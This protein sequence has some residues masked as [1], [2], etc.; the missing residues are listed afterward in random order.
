MNQETIEQLRRLKDAK[1]FFAIAEEMALGADPPT[2]PRKSCAVTGW[3]AVSPAGWNAAALCESTTS[4]VGLATK[5]E[6]RCS[7]APARQFRPVPPHSAP[8]DWMKQP[9]FRRNTAVARFAVHAA[10]EALGESKLAQVQSGE[11]RIGIIFCTMNGCVQFSRRFFTEVLDNP[12]LASPIFF[13][14]T[15]YNAPSSHIAAILGAHDIN[16]TLVGDSAQ[17]IAGLALAEQWLTDGVVEACLVVAAE[18]L[19]WL[20]DEAIMLFGKRRVAA[21]GAAAV[22][23]EPRTQ[24]NDTMPVLQHVT[25]TRT[26]GARLSRTQA[27][28]EV[29][30]E[31]ELLSEFKGAV[32]F[33]GLGVGKHVDEPEEEAW[34]TWNQERVSVRRVL[35][36]GLAAT[37]GWQVVAA[38][39]WLRTGLA[40]QSLVSA[41]GLSQQAAGAAFGVD[42]R[43][44]V[45]EKVLQTPRAL[46]EHA[47]T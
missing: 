7:G 26:F 32:L 21:E 2:N 6:S 37:S 9:R 23:L 22:L 10:V 16:Y 24:N 46:K 12:A 29:A 4:G 36:E 13:P 8:P 27:A 5:S 3:G 39:E 15:V 42:P 1:Q 17:F 28:R 44:G 40:T 33:D 34:W 43:V 20:S 19:D 47:A 35:G 14:E 38:L 11:W 18:E 45:V 30:Q 25:R 41:V 31:L